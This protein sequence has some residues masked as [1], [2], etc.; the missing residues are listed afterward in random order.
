MAADKPGPSGNQNFFHSV[1][2]PPEYQIGLMIIF[3]MIWHGLLILSTLGS[4]LD[5][6]PS[7]DCAIERNY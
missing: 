6:T 3:F 4:F 5:F 1:P 2:L 7:L